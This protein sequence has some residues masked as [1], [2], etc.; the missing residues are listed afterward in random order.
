MRTA[1]SEQIPTR[2]RSDAV[3]CE[4][5]EAAMGLVHDWP[6]KQVPSEGDGN[7]GPRGSRHASHGH[8]VADGTIPKV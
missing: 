6:E 2:K 5:A 1:A 7:C 4:C 3:A 8:I